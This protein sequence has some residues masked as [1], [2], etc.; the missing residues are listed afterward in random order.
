MTFSSAD[1]K[2]MHRRLAPYRSLS[3]RASHVAARSTRMLVDCESEMICP[4]GLRTNT[5]PDSLSGLCRT[6]AQAA[7]RLMQM[8]ISVHFAAVA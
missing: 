8:S 5:V 3:M 7:A 4:S 1:H 6:L 2:S